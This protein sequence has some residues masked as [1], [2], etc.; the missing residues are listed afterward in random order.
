MSDDELKLNSPHDVR[1]LIRTW[2]AEVCRTRKL[3]FE[4]AGSVVQLLNT[5][6]RSYEIEKV[7]DLEERISHLEEAAK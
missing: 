3:P 1:E 4:G 7:S 6:L 2:I 5:W